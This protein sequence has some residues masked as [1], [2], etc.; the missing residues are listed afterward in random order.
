MEDYST[1]L[2]EDYS[3]VLEEQGYTP[4]ING[5]I[6][7]VF[8]DDL[9][10]Y[11]NHIIDI[12]DNENNVFRIEIE[13]NIIDISAYNHD[14]NILSRTNGEVTV[15]ETIYENNESNN[16]IIENTTYKNPRI[17]YLDT[18]V[19]IFKN[20]NEYKFFKYIF[21][22]FLDKKMRYIYLDMNIN[23]INGIY[24]IFDENTFNGNN[25]FFTNEFLMDTILKVTEIN[26]IK[27]KKRRL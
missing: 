12:T 14:V 15:K 1:V 21:P 19:Y 10:D 24:Y 7:N 4:F 9:Y 13:Y 16:F 22:L 8:D 27:E 23:I 11:F 17:Y 18:S 6:S 3:T 26:N 20:N 2:E 25:T 5:K